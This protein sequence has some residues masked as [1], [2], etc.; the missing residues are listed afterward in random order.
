VRGTLSFY[1]PKDTT[2]TN[3]FEVLEELKK[4]PP[5][6]IESVFLDIKYFPYIE[7][8]RKTAEALSKID[9]IKLSPDLDYNSINGLSTESKEKLTGARPLSVGQAARISGIRQGDIALLTVIAK[10]QK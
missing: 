6:W 9:A 5:E 4:Y 1:T 10:R 8:E 7:K 3:G 2:K